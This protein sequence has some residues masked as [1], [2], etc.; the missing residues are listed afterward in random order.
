MA[1]FQ[2]MGGLG[3][4]G[5]VSD[6]GGFFQ[7]PVVQDTLN[8]VFDSMI[9]SP[10]NNIMQNFS[11]SYDNS[12]ERRS[13]AEQRAAFE[14][15]LISAGMDPAQAKMMAASPQAAKFTLEQQQQKQEQEAA[16]TQRNTTLE[17][18]RAAD[19]EIATMVEAGLPVADGFKMH[20]EKRNGKQQGLMN[21]GDGAIY[22]PNTGTWLTAPGKTSKPPAIE[23]FYDEKSGQPYNA[24]WNAE[25]NSWERVG[26][27]KAPSGMSIT[28]NP[29]GT[30]S[31]TQG[32]TGGGKMTELNSKDM[33]YA[34]RAAGALPII[35]SMGDALTSLPESVGGQA[36]VVGNYMKSPQYQQAEQ[37]GK[38]FLQA[39]LRKDT[40]A[41]ITTQ[42][43]NEYGTV[44]LPGPGDYPE[45]LAQK[46]ASRQRA[47]Q[48]L[49]AGIPPDLIL[50]LE[51]SGV[52]LPAPAA[53]GAKQPVVID[54]YTI[55][56]VD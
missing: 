6:T 31:V 24:Q 43:M 38:E 14:Q 32:P 23:T 29:D 36:P 17:F 10:R 45:L 28:T 27:V 52:Q 8:A 48:A 39:I 40:G 15:A 7:R 13:Q 47:L 37:A 25:T 11:Q 44:Y 54:G 9:S 53:A 3:G 21:A 22:D 51:K 34:T 4:L 2:N 12:L 42:E 1:G 35:D 41:A 55:E 5:G 50:K 56:Q 33:V 46:K 20:L 49:A 18:L 16:N 19:P 26:G 30:V